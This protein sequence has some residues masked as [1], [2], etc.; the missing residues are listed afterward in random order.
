[1]EVHFKVSQWERA[2]KGRWLCLSTTTFLRLKV[3][4]DQLFSSKPV[5]LESNTLQMIIR[6]F[7]I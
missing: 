3:A 2:D 5:L 6:L 1:M 4:E 7:T